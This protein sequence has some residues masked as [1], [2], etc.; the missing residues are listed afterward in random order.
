MFVVMIDCF[1]DSLYLSCVEPLLFPVVVLYAFYKSLDGG[2][3]IEECVLLQDVDVFP[4]PLKPAPIRPTVG[5]HQGS[6]PAPAGKMN[7]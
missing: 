4:A 5:K 3:P 1:Q 2:F 6:V 7:E